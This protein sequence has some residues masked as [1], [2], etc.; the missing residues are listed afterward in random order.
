MQYVV[1]EV[2]S[3]FCNETDALSERRMPGKQPG[4]FADFLR[5]RA[6]YAVLSTDGLSDDLQPLK[7]DAFCDWLVSEF[8]DLEA[9]LRWRRL[10]GMLKAWPTA[11]HSDDKTIAVLRVAAE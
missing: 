4:R 3:G 6:N 10:A 8:S 9:N 7:R 2:R 1:G 5:P 11:G